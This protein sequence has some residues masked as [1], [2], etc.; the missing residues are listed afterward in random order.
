MLTK[1]TKITIVI[2]CDYCG[3]S[4]IYGNETEDEATKDWISNDGMI[5]DDGHFCDLVCKTNWEGLEKDE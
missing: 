1:H 4:S 2:K 3:S 5:T